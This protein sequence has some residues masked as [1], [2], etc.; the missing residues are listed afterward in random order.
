MQGIFEKCGVYQPTQPEL[1]INL[2]DYW[3]RSDLGMN[4]VFFLL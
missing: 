3:F 1:E 4:I 2:S